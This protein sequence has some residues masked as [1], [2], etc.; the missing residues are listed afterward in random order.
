[1]YDLH[2]AYN[3]ENIVFIYYVQFSIHVSF[4][5]EFIWRRELGGKL[6]PN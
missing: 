2:N 3:Y 6:R 1:M 4:A 5:C